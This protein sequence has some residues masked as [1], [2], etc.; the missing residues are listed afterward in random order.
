MSPLIPTEEP[1]PRPSRVVAEAL[2]QR[3]GPDRIVS[4]ASKLGLSPQLT[5]AIVVAC[6]ATAVDPLGSRRRRIVGSA[7]R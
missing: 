6:G 7:H 5:C 2:V 1:A 3:H 4:R